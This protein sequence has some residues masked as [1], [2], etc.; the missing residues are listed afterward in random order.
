MNAN[1]TII[2]MS[3]TICRRF[4]N[5]R[6]S[7]PRHSLV[8][9]FKNPTL[10]F[11]MEQHGL[12]RALN[13]QQDFLPRSGAFAVL[14]GEVFE[15]AK[16]C[17]AIAMH[18]LRN[19]FEVNALNTEYEFSDLLQHA[20]KMHAAVDEKTLQLGLYLA[21]DFGAFRGLK[22]SDDLVTIERF[23][24]AEGIVTVAD[25][26]Q[27][28]EERSASARSVGSA[29][30]AA[31]AEEVEREQVNTD[32]I[33]SLLHPAIH[34]IAAPRYEAGFYADAVEACLKFVDEEV[35]ARTKLDKDGH[36]LMAA[37][38]S[39]ENPLLILGDVAT[40][41]G[42]SM[43][44]GYMQIFSGAMTGIRNPKAHGNLQIDRQRCIHFLFLASLLAYKLD[45]AIDTSQQG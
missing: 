28:W 11:V 24:I 4:L 40:A 36:K 20:Y 1:K 19:M 37:A 35:R 29:Q 9:A 15:R 3:D 44:Q 41:T 13:N 18:T 42:R 21:Q 30:F 33:W 22:P 38:F 32:D 2:E 45:E 10:L 14:T 16:L 25:P 27:L 8:V 39:L 17:M 6:T 7:S 34:Q 5:M 23:T 26:D 12:V 43:Q 31:A